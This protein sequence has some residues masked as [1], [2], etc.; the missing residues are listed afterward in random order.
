MPLASEWREKPP[1]PWRSWDRAAP[2]PAGRLRQS[3]GALGWRL[4]TGQRK[5]EVRGAIPARRTRTAFPGVIALAFPPAVSHSSCEQDGGQDEG[6]NEQVGA[7]Y[8]PH[9]DAM[10]LI[11]LLFVAAVEMDVC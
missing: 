10:N 11:L 7:H 9:S 3:S 8:F 6:N 1:P 2:A 5:Q 4:L